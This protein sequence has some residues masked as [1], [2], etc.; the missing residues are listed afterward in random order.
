MLGEYFQENSI[1]AERKGNNTLY[2]VYIYIYR[3]RER[4]KERESKTPVLLPVIFGP[5]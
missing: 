5:Q 4:E 2:Y 3:E 1:S